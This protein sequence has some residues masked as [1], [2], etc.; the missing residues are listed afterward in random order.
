[1]Q[2][3]SFMQHK[4]TLFWNACSKVDHIHLY[5]DWSITHKKKHIDNCTRNFMQSCFISREDSFSRKRGI[6][7][8][9]ADNFNESFPK[10]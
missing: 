6:Y 9:I 5:I 4:F 10:N 1:L 2:L 8:G 3:I 7:K